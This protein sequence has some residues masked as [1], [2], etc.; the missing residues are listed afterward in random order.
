YKEYTWGD[1]EFEQ[2]RACMASMARWNEGSTV[3]E[4]DLTG[5]AS[6]RA[7]NGHRRIDHDREQPRPAGDDGQAP[8][9][10]EGT[11]PD[12]LRPHQSRGRRRRGRNGPAA[13]GAVDRRQ[14]PG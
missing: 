9:R 14:R 1:L 7:A 4:A 10:R 11:E 13:D 5:I 12:R 3:P 8:S 2:Y 6:E